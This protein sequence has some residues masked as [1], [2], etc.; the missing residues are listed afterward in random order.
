MNELYIIRCTIS[1]W[2]DYPLVAYLPIP[3][4]KYSSSTYYSYIVGATQVIYLSSGGS[5]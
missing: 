2:G 4:R 5:P 3:L 1:D